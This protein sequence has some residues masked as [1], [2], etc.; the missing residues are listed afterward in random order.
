MER[1]AAESAIPC[2]LPGPPHFYTRARGARLW[3]AD[4]RE[5]IDY[6]GGLGPNLLGY[7]HPE[8]EAAAERQ[9]AR[10]ATP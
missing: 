6:L 1:C 8:V 3:D 9:R 4:G 2:Y 7:G 5:Y 10:W